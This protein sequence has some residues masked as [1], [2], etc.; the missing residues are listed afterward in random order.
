MAK[1][2][3]NL[4]E[5]FNNRPIKKV[6][7]QVEGQITLQDWLIW[8][9]DIRN[10]LQETAENFVVIGYRLK[11]IR[12]SRM[13]EKEYPSLNDFAYHEYNLSKS[14][15]SRFIKI[16]NR[17]SKNGNSMELKDE[18]KEYGYSQLQEMLSL[19]QEEEEE[20]TPEMTVREIRQIKESRN[21]K[22]EAELP[23][24]DAPEET[25]DSEESEESNEDKT[26]AGI[27][28]KVATSQPKGRDSDD[29][30]WKEKKPESKPIELPKKDAVYREKAG[31]SLLKEITE[32]S[33]RYL[34]TKMRH[35]YRVGNTLILQEHDKGMPT[36]NIVKIQIAHMTD[37]SGGILPGYCVIGFLDFVIDK[38]DVENEVI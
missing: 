15:V 5:V 11:Q 14:V 25:L 36:G 28:E 19:T 2:K 23:T 16:N 21:K 1:S 35:K 30:C 24:E 18:Y 13:F 32:G 22:E 9:E 10:R 4:E 27:K 6:E 38:E 7:T 34:V 31:V 33:R 26:A 37:D 20:V 17:Y 8:K 3:F 29:D 12:D